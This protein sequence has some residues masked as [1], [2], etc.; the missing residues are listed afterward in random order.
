MFSQNRRWIVLVVCSLFAT[1]CGQGGSGGGSSSGN[2]ASWQ[3][4]N[5]GDAAKT[6]VELGLEYL[7]QGQVARAKSKLI[8]A[9]KLSP[10]L[11]EAHSAL[12][13]F[14]ER[15]GDMRSRTGT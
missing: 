13:Y 11:P 1:A 6:N 12:A 15:A 9:A 2:P 8:H 10:N 3:M 14:Y 5:A 4:G 7:S